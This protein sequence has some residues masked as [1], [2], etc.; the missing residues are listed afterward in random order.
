M[1]EIVCPPLFDS[2]FLET[3]KKERHLTPLTIFQQWLSKCPVCLGQMYVTEVTL[4]DTGSRMLT[5]GKLDEEGFDV[6]PDNW[7]FLQGELTPGDTR[8][9]RAECA[10]CGRKWPLADLRL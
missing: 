2:M 7:R 6:R 3:A 5:W 9:E 1:R 4:R 10:N 8:N